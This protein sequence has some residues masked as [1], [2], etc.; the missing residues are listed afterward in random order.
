M[1]R[2]DKTGTDSYGFSITLMFTFI[3]L[4]FLFLGSLIP[5][6]AIVFYFLSSMCI[7]NVMYE[8]K[9]HYALISF[10]I[11]AF[12]CALIVP[13]FNF[14]LPYIILFGH[15]GIFKYIIE[16]KRLRKITIAVKY[17]YFSIGLSIIYL[18]YPAFFNENYYGLPSFVYIIIL[19]VA[20][21]FYDKLYSKFSKY[22]E[23]ILRK[24]LKNSLY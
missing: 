17:I 12:L 13:D 15:Y 6:A 19:E 5:A 1:Y 9:F 23:N 14:T 20:F 24:I 2:V 10:G 22:Y 4:L 16:K 18:L 8:E 7:M 3:S 11:S 21:F